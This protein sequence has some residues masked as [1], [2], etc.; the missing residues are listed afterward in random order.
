[1]TKGHAGAAGRPT[2]GTNPSATTAA[3]IEMA[4]V[5]ASGSSPRLM[6]AF[7]AA[8]QAA[9]NSTAVKTKVSIGLRVPRGCDH[10]A[11]EP[12]SIRDRRGC[13]NRIAGCQKD[14]ADAPSSR[15]TE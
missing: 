12:G 14:K 11:A 1:M 13:R 7:Q 2:K 9:A 3:P 10:E 5:M 4:T 15:N 8:W 6:V